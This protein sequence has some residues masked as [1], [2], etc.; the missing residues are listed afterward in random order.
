MFKFK[1]IKNCFND[2]SNVK[3]DDCDFLL[4]TD[5]WNDYWFYTLYHLHATP[6]ILREKQTRYLGYLKILM[7]GQKEYQGNLVADYVADKNGCFM[8]LNENFCSISFS[9]DFYKEISFILQ[10]KEERQ[11]FAKSLN[12]I[13]DIDNPIY[14]KFKDE[15]GFE[16]SFL[17]SATMDDYSLSYGRYLLFSDKTFFPLR[18]KSIS[19]SFDNDNSIDINFSSSNNTKSIEWLPDGIVA[20]VGR[21]GVGKSSTLYNLAK[22]I[23]MP[24]E[25]REMMKSISV[26]PNDLGVHKMILISYSAFDNFTLPGETYSDFIKLAE[27]IDSY[28]RGRFVYC[29][30]RDVK[31]EINKRAKEIKNKAKD[32]NNDEEINKILNQPFYESDHISDSIIKPIGTLANEFH[33]A[34]SKIHSNNELEK[35]W[36]GMLHRSRQVH[37]EFYEYLNDLDPVF[38]KSMVIE[39]FTKLSTGHKFFSHALAHIIAYTENNSLILFDEPEN[40]LHPPFLSFMMSEIRRILRERES[41]ML[42]ATHSPIILQETFSRNTIVVRRTGNDI[43]VAH[44]EAEIYGNTIG[45]INELVFD[46]TSDITKYHSAIDGLYKK[47]DC[48]KDANVKE[49]LSKLTKELGME[50]LSAQLSSYIINKFYSDKHVG[51]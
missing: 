8:Q 19:V 21:N 28:N 44:P 42:V 1:V 13:F 35:Q 31:E 27:N 10:S 4:E 16:K 24:T 25:K 40:H 47:L 26:T 51:S 20:F 43:N 29:G 45:N 6:K 12:M 23:Y 37:E 32:A 41:V 39:R 2:A 30:V 15:E 18:E 22:W 11:L 33:E 46:L 34:L 3:S 36:L 14:Q 50:H 9:P 38:E 5:N 49:T 48:R 17:R 7:K